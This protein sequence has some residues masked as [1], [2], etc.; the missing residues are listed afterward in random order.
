MSP[1][2]CLRIYNRLT[3]RFCDGARVFP[4]KVTATSLAQ[5]SGYL[6]W[7][8]ASAVDPER[9][10]RA[11]H[12]AT[13]WRFRI[14]LARLYQVSD[15]FIE[16]F[17]DWGDGKQVETQINEHLA[18]IVVAD[19]DCKTELTAL[20]E[21]AKAEFAQTP[22]V[23]LLSPDMTLGHHPESVWCVQCRLAAECMAALPRHIKIAR[24]RRP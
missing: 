19:T 22:E 23:C 5:C 10:I 12:D 15:G 6:E 14:P 2:R 7:C 3:A 21:R 9:F 24:G 8:R 16:K 13:G 4:R 20:S 17:K 18:T 11:R 1:R